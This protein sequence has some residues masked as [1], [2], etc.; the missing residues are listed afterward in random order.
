[1]NLSNNNMSIRVYRHRTPVF[2]EKQIFKMGLSPIEFRVYCQLL[3]LAQEGTEEDSEVACQCYITSEELEAAYQNL[4]FLNLINRVGE[5]I[6][7]IDPPQEEHEPQIKIS[8]QITFVKDSIR[9]KDIPLYQPSIYVIKSDL[10]GLTK[11]GITTSP[12][13]RIKSIVNK[14]R[15]DVEVLAIIRC[16]VPKDLEKFLHS[17]FKRKQVIFAQEQEWFDLSVEDIEEIGTLTQSFVTR[18]VCNE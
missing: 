13:N 17:R 7:L 16:R 5:A 9:Y 11:I 4:E 12:R 2:I 6:V 18:E 15:F 3:Y 10:N 1:M 8:S 14:H